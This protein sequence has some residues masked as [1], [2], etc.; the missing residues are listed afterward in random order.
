MFNITNL[1]KSFVIKSLRPAAS[2]NSLSAITSI[3][4][5]S[6]NN[7]TAQSNVFQNR[8][9]EPKATPAA[10]TESVT[11]PAV[12]EKVR[13]VVCGGGIMGT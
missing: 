4:E 1:T 10:P 13:V 3:R 11:P 8:E 6:S 9:F 7:V 2:R 5:I 12:P